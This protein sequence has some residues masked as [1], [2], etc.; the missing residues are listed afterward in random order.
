MSYARRRDPRRCVTR[1]GVQGDGGRRDG[2]ACGRSRELVLG[3]RRGYDG[4]RRGAD[5][6][7][8]RRASEHRAQQRSAGGEVEHAEPRPWALQSAHQRPAGA[9]EQGLHRGK[10]QAELIGNVGV[11]QSLPL[12]QEDPGAAAP[13]AVRGRPG[14]ARSPRASR[15]SAT[16]RRPRA[17]PRP[18]WR[19][20]RGAGRACAST[21]GRRCRRSSATTRA[22]SGGSPRAA[23]TRVRRGT[24]SG[25]HPGPL[26]GCAADSGRSC[27]PAARG[28]RTGRLSSP[29]RSWPRG[30]RRAARSRRDRQPRDLRQRR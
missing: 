13:A 20:A 6:R 28:G 12:A 3:D 15:R 30:R 7:L 18:R 8:A 25:R 24:R 11:A 27:R 2:W 17:R 23:T 1:R 29:R 10:R 22:R 16:G 26:P 9:E 14:A 21:S 19:R 5:G 4:E